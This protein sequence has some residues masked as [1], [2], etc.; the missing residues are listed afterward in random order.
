MSPSRKR[1]PGPP[2]PPGRKGK[3]RGP[4]GGKTTV[5]ADGKLIRKTFYIDRDVEEKLRDEA[6]EH[7]RTEAEIVR[8][9]LRERYGLD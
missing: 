1:P 6:H 2:D 8:W 7:R 9:V 3:E 5:S 4:R